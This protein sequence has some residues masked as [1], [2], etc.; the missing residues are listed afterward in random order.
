MAPQYCPRLPLPRRFFSPF[1]NARRLLLLLFLVVSTAAA[2]IKVQVTVIDK[3]TSEPVENLSASDFT[4]LL[5]RSPRIVEAA[6]FS[7]GPIDVML[8]VDSS[9]MGGLVQQVASSFIAELQDKEQMA[10]VAFASSA[11]L[12]QDFTASKPL[13]AAALGRIKYGNAPKVLDALYAAMD[14]GFDHAALRRVIFLVTA[15]FEGASQVGQRE[16]IRLARKN[17][18]TIYPV[19]ATGA[20]RSL[21]ESLARQTGGASFS[22]RDLARSGAASPAA[23]IF[24]VARGYYTLTLR[25]NLGLGEN[26]SVEIKR[27]QK[28]FVSVLPLD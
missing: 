18:V 21:L 6:E 4:V 15:G 24:R 8:M 22:L 28:L 7:R 9:L 2:A 19:Y 1:G 10:I 23:H 26:V 27:P 17:G 13:L 11:E 16:V 14:G 3:K 20:E 5:D 12:V 25:G